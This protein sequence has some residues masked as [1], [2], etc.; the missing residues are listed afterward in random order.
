MP[1]SDSNPKDVKSDRES[2]RKRE[3]DRDRHRR[4]HETKVRDASTQTP[5]K[6][7]DHR[8]SKRD[9]QQPAAPKKIMLGNAREPAD[10]ACTSD[11]NSANTTAADMTREHPPS[12]VARAGR[13]P[14]AQRARMYLAYS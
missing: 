14:A 9:D 6:W 12:P 4:R 10:P 8:R 11:T 7:D 13:R 3:R 2:S 1:S 5:S